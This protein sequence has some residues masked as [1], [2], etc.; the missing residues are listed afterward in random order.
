M[1]YNY[2]ETGGPMRRIQAVLKHRVALGETY[3]ELAEKCSTTPKT[4]SN[5]V[6]NS[7]DLKWYSLFDICLGLE[8][9]LKDIFRDTR[10]EKLL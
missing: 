2:K 10:W 8:L 7:P 9:E 5:W 6:R 3:K 1:T 4:I